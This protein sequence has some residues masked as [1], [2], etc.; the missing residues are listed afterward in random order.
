MTGRLA[1]LATAQ[2]GVVARRQLFDLGHTRRMIDGALTRG[3]LHRLHRGVYA[4]GHLRLSGDGRWMAAVL[5]CGEG[6]ALSHPDGAA[7][8]DLRARPTGDIHVSAPG[9]HRLP[10]IRCHCVA[11]LDAADTTTVLGIP[12][13]T[14]E[15]TALDLAAEL[16]RTRLTDLLERME[17]RRVFDLTALTATIDRNHGHHGV[18][19]L[20]AALAALTDEPPFTQSELERALRRIAEAAGLLTPAFNV[21]VEGYCCDV[22][23]PPQRLIVEVDGWETHGTRRQVE[24]DRER[25]AALTVAGWR[26]IRLTYRRITHDA[27]AVVAQL[28]ILLERG[29]GPWPLPGR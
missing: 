15:R 21:M 5:A 8:H 16:P 2:F 22:V 11:A 28:R 12:V 10:G 25:D 1:T 19:P 23:W 26:L 20:R 13:T 7:L 6:T 4:V 9:R 17:Q 29:A 18:K 27:A 3:E 24:S 14:I